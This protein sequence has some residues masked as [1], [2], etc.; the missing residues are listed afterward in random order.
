MLWED[1][2]IKLFKKHKPIKPDEIK[3]YLSG[4]KL[5][6]VG[7]GAFRDVYRIGTLNLVAKFPKTYI[8]DFDYEDNVSHALHEIKLIKKIKKFKK[9]L[10]LK[11]FL[12]KLHYANTKNGVIVTDYCPAIRPSAIGTAVSNIINPLFETV[13]KRKNGEDMD[14]HEYNI[15][16]THD[17]FFKVI[18]LGMI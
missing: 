7:S 9:Y 1:D 6:K 4:L 11:P 14:I 2:V 13:L 10:A 8:S 15:G 18:D 12:T 5:R 17:G 16:R 3:P